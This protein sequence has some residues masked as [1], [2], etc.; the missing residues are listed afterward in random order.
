MV[1]TNILSILILKNNNMLVLL[2]DNSEKNIHNLVWTKEKNWLISTL[3]MIGVNEKAPIPAICVEIWS[4]FMISGY[5][6]WIFFFL[7]DRIQSWKDFKWVLGKRIAINISFFLSFC[8][9]RIAKFIWTYE[10]DVK[11]MVKLLNLL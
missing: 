5:M 9:A 11:I 1:L 4:R 2:L 10:E 3:F 8:T 6:F 7:K